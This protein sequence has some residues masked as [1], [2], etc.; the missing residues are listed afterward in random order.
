MESPKLKPYPNWESHK[1]PQGG[2]IIEPSHI[3]SPFRVRADQCGRLWVLD[4]GAAELLGNYKAYASSRVLVFDLH[5]DA[6]LRVFTIPQSQIKEESFFAT[7][8]VEDHDCANT[9]GYFA[10]L[11]KAGLIVY[12]WKENKS[13]RVKHNYFNI[14]PLAGEFNVSGITFQW[15]DHLF[16]LAL[17]APDSEGFSTLY[18][19]PMVSTNE[20]AVST[21]YLRDEKLSSTSYNEFRLLGNRGPNAQSSVSFLDKNTGVL[22]YALVNLNAVACW[23]TSNPSYNMQSQGRIYMSNVTMVFPNDIKVDSKGN[24]WVL[25]DR[26]PQFMYKELDPEDVNFRILTAP[27]QDAIKGTACDSKLIISNLPGRFKPASTTLAPIQNKK[28]S[29][30]S[31]NVISL[32]SFVFCLLL[33]KF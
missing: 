30:A 26:L 25:S 8:A 23:R 15:T 10:D 3:I 6:L 17:S 33:H 21:K 19:H 2:S 29:D 28:S 1:L 11:G 22:F 9:F 27:V 24:L 5:N 31:S 32:L 14:D 12:S 18:F 7:L 20:F 16:G 13:W 4:T